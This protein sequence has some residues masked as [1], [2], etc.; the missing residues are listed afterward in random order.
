MPHSKSSLLALGATS[1]HGQPHKC[2]NQATNWPAMYH[3]LVSFPVLVHSF[4]R[5]CQQMTG[6]I[7]YVA[8]TYPHTVYTP[9][10]LLYNIHSAGSCWGISPSWCPG[11]PN[12]H[13]MR[14]ITSSSWDPLPSSTQL[15][16]WLE[17]YA[18]S[19][20]CWHIPAILVGYPL[21]SSIDPLLIIGY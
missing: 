2:N 19:S 10:T 3:Q 11:D 5:K 13:P 12:E 1:I 16:G 18:S 4:S 20:Y 21:I 15:F 7:Q 9:A 17:Y 6:Q 8:G 14:W